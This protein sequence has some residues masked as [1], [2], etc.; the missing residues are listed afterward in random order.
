MK[1]IRL[2]LDGQISEYRLNDEAPWPTSPT[3]APRSRMVYAAAHVVIDPLQPDVLDIEATLAFR[4][5]L[6]SLGFGVAE[7][8]DTAQRGMGLSWITARDLIRASAGERK[9]EIACGA[10]TDQLDPTVPA[11]LDDVIR[12]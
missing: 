1:K 3:P 5:H 4:R 10:N 8:M 6:W 2:P 7:A 9:G 11:T 12:A